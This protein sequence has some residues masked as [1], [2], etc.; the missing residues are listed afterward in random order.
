MVSSSYIDLIFELPLFNKDVKQSLIEKLELKKIIFSTEHY[1]EI[2]HNRHL[3]LCNWENKCYI[4]DI[5]IISSELFQ[6]TKFWFKGPFSLVNSFRKELYIGFQEILTPY[7][8]FDLNGNCIN[9]QTVLDNDS[10]FR[11]VLR[12]PVSIDSSAIL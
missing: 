1:V 12:S 10:F 5:K 3:F 11:I 2:S 4:C 8:L 9:H 7:G 6:F